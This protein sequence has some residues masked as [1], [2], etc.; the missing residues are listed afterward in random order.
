MVMEMSEKFATIEN[1]IWFFLGA[2]LILIVEGLPLSWLNMPYFLLL[3]V[4]YWARFR[5]FDGLLESSFMVGLIKDLIMPAP[6]VGVT[7]VLLVI[8]C[9]FMVT[10]N[11]WVNSWLFWQRWLCYGALISGFTVAYNA[12]LWYQGTVANIWFLWLQAA[13]SVFVWPFWVSLMR[14]LCPPNRRRLTFGY[15]RSLS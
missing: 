14:Y 7:A 11:Q 3:L 5:P 2:F 8:V 1:A 4:L 15:N 13:T 12:I 10:I 6:Y 9:Y